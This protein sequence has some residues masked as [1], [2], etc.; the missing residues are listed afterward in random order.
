MT[1]CERASLWAQTV[2]GVLAVTCAVGL[3]VR[4]AEARSCGAR[5]CWAGYR[6]SK[7]APYQGVAAQIEIYDPAFS[8]D[9]ASFAWVDISDRNGT[10]NAKASHWIQA[11]YRKEYP[12][13]PLGFRCSYAESMGMC[14]QVTQPHMQFGNA[15]QV[16]SARYFMVYRVGTEYRCKAA[17]LDVY[18]PISPGGC[19]DLTFEK[20]QVGWEAETTDNGNRLVGFPPPPPTDPCEFKDCKYTTTYDPP[21]WQPSHLE[22]RRLTC[23]DAH[24]VQKDSSTSFGVWDQMN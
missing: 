22:E 3:S 18:L 5:Q 10:G 6:D 20:R 11:G 12:A 16:G 13:G 17:D 14:A 19:D 7:E 8:C 1:G 24:G 15:P 2:V 23:P 9:G 21:V 4:W